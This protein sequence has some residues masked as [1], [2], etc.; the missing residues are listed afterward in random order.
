VGRRNILEVWRLALLCLLWCIWRE[1]NVR[2]F[3]DQET[4][5]VD[6]KRIM[7]NSL[8][9]W[10]ATHNNLLFFFFPSF[11][12]FLDFCSSFSQYRFS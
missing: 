3:E 9:T 11:S 4:L 5:V 1:R 8:Y 7:F 6:P 2:S 12:E 10:I